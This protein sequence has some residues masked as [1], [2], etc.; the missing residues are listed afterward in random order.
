[1]IYSKDALNFDLNSLR[2]LSPSGITVTYL[3]SNDVSATLARHQFQVS[4][5]PITGDGN[6]FEISATLL[7]SRNFQSTQTLNVS[8]MRPCA[9][10][11]TTGDS[12]AIFNCAITKRFVTF[13]GMN[14]DLAPPTPN[15]STNGIAK[16]DFVMGIDNF[17]TIDVVNANGELI[18]T[19]VKNWME[20]GA[21]TM[22]FETNDLSSGVYFVRMQSSNY[23][24]TV[25]L[26]IAK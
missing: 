12:T 13:S 10:V 23:N 7:L 9:I 1:V 11:S 21:Y 15:P 26:L 8:G 22:E 19:L 4:G 14:P 18:R 5:G 25:K 24:E 20:V 2:A 16:L 3:G 6:L 17:V